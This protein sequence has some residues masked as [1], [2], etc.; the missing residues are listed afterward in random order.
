MKATVMLEKIMTLLNADVKTELSSMK[1][2]NGTVLE[3]EMF[4]PGEPVFIVTEDETVALPV[5]DYTLEDGKMLVVE[6]E[7]II[8]EIKES[9]E[10]AVTEEVAPTGESVTEMADEPVTEEA[11]AETKEYVTMEDFASLVAEFNALKDSLAE[12]AETAEEVKEEIKEELSSKKFKHNPE[13]GVK[14][15]TL[16]KVATKGKASTMD[17]VYSRMFNN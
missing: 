5:G 4:E 11:P 8:A 17:R 14:K 16:K 13:A 9:E 1:L 12:V 2:E 7:G 6:E 15:Q 10:D 3:A